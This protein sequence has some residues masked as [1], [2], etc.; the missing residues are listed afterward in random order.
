ML[1]QILREVFF[2][3]RCCVCFDAGS[4]FCTECAP[5]VH[6]RHDELLETAAMPL[7]ALGAY[8]GNLR[9][10]VLA[11]K[12]GRRDVAL[13]AALHLAERLSDLPWLHG[14]TLVPMPTAAY[15]VRLRGVDGAVFMAI[16][17]AERLGLGIMP[18][19]RSRAA[20]AQRG[21]NRTQRLEAAGRF[22]VRSATNLQGLRVVLVDD[23]VTTGA[24]LRE[25]GAALQTHGARVCGALALARTLSNGAEAET[26]E[27]ESHGKSNLE[28]RHAGGKRHL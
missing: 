22:F 23:V 6:E 20:W 19:L 2:P 10:A 13:A 15:R 24:S 9:S 7:R 4:A 14:A 27:E 18:V 3:P 28:R 12:D 25:A 5:Y 21:R 1:A 16:A 17:I 11:L 26:E 8:Q